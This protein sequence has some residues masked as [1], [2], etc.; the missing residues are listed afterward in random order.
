M[1]FNLSAI[2]VR[3]RAVTLFFILL[4]AAAGVYAFVKL[5]RAEDPNFTI[6]ALTVT[7]AW[8]GATAREMQD[9]VAE[10]LEKRI[11]EL[12]WYDRVETTTRPGYAFLTVTLKDST[13]P[14][15]APEEF[16]QARKKLGD[17]ARNLPPG[18]LGPFVN[19]EYSDVSFGLYALKAKGMPMR[20]LARRAEVIRQDLLHVPGVKK[21]NILGERPEQIFVEFSFAKLAT[22]GVSA[23]DIA[24]ALQRQNPVTPAGSIDTRGPQVF[25]RFDGEYAGNIFWVVGFALIVSWIVAMVFTPYM[26][27]KLL[28]AIRPIEGGYR[29]IH[30]TP[31]Y[32]RLRGAIALAVR[33][34][35]LTCA[36]V[37]GA[38]IASGVGMGAVK[39]RFFPTS[40]RPE[41]L[42]EVRLPEGASIETTT[43]AVEKLERWLWKQPES[44]IAT[45]YSGKAHRASSLRWRRN[46]RTQPSPR[47]SS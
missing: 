42:V 25:I 28:P 36:I 11:Q 27:V 9:L 16:Y 18:V 14:S 35:Y 2:A 17:E 23:Q 41:V 47:S 15:E 37:A 7:A 30:D 12:T 26:G 10:S 5:G 43:L 31:N 20:E 3:E 44:K 8:P 24:T 38:L 32:R 46:C 22:L 45:S 29:A 6:K 39:Q 1:S 19:D 40:D 33:H 21:I 34:K 13:P 4:L